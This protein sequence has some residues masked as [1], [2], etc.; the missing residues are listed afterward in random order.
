MAGIG[1]KLNNIYGKNTLTTDIIGIGYSTV[2]T[3]APMLTVIGALCFM[4]KFLGFDS[5]GYTTRELFSCTV[6][7]IFIFALL[8]ASPFNS[9]LSRYMSDV[10]YQETF[11]DILPCYYVGMILNI[12]LSSLVGIAFCIHEYLVG[13]VDI[14]YVFTGYCGYIALVLVFY[15]MLYLSICKD[16]KK[17]SFFFIIGMTVTVLLSFWFVRILSWSITYGMLLALTIGFWLI[18]CL[19]FS[20]VRSY[21][22]ENSG[23]YREVLKYF[24][25]YWPLVATNFLYTLGLYVHNFV[26]WT[27]DLRKIVVESFVCVT[28]YDMATCLAMFTNI[29][30]SVI[31]ISR[32]EM[33]FHERYKAYSEAVIGGRGADIEITKKRMFRMLSE[34]LMSLA[35]VQFIITLVIFLLCMIF[36]PQLGFGGMTLRIYPCLSAGYFILFLMYAE[37]IFL[38]YF[39][40]LTGSVLTALSFC[41]VTFVGSLISTHFSEVWYGMG[42]TVG[43]FTGWT[44]AYWR[45]RWMEK[46]LDVHIFCSGHL[47]K[48]QK[49]ECPS[50][51]VFDRYEG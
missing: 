41:A 33:N 26:F 17:I 44:V 38:Y 18:A 49:G 12:T 51:K 42:L 6:L 21:F 43:S 30:A 20:V 16:Y 5:V 37:I 34:E 45:L 39:N 19:E 25:D 4:E 32:V 47:L 1:V 23:K 11:E 35:R 9:V 13:K 14:I 46:N 36:L 22:R 10:I 8:T 40:D 15:S 50:P 3:I 48:Q 28:T 24:R 31:F 27:T 29:S 7:Y 2:V